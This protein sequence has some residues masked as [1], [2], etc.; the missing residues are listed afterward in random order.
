M[1]LRV[2]G[3]EN[4]PPA[5]VA[6]KVGKLGISPKI[7]TDAILKATGPYKGLRVTVKVAVQNRQATAEIV[8]SA[9]TLIIK[10]LKEPA[11]DRKK[12]KNS[13]FKLT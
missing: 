10:A 11:R 8:P 3:G 13:T 7:V 4:V 1:Y 5:I 12:T 2:Y 9:S 6:P